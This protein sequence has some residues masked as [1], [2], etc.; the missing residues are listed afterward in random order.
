MVPAESVVQFEL[1]AV[2]PA[3]VFQVELRFPRKYAAA[4]V[5]ADSTSCSSVPVFTSVRV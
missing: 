4:V 2:P 3:N 1:F 5:L